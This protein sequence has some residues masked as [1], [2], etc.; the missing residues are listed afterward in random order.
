MLVRRCALFLIAAIIM[1]GVIEPGLYTALALSNSVKKFD[2]NYKL[3]PLKSEKVQKTAPL[4]EATG[5]TPEPVVVNPRGHKYEEV[6]KRTPFTSTYVNNDGTR[7]LQYSVRQQNYKD[8]DTWQKIDNTLTGTPQNIP[9]VTMPQA[10]T[11]PAQMTPAP[12]QFKG[13][14]GAIAAEMNSLSQGVTMNLAGKTITMRPIGAKDVKPVKGDDNSVTYPNAWPNVDL[15]Y[16]LRGEAVKEIIIIKDK[17]A[18]TTF[19]FAVTG[20]T[21]I[22]HP[23][24]AGELTVSGLPDEYSFSALTLDVNGRGVISEQRVTQ[25]PT[26]K[27]DGVTVAM[28]ASWMKAQPASSFPLRI[29]PSLSKDS[30]SYWMFKSDGYSCGTNCYANIGAIYDTSWKNWRT[31]VQFPYTELSGKKVV[32]ATLHG[33]F[34]YGQNGD[35]SGHYIWMG[36]APCISYGCQGGQ[37]GSTYA[38]TDFDID[39]TGALSSV[40]SAGDM[41]AVWSLWGEEG[42]YKSYKPYYDIVANITYDSPTPV[43]PTIAPVDQQVMVDTQP[44]LKVGAVTDPDGPVQYHFSVATNTDGKTGAVIQSD[45]AASPTW[46]VPEGVLQDGTTYYWRVYTRDTTSTSQSTEGPVQS[47]KV[48]LRTGKDSTQSYDTIGPV[49]VDLATGNATIAASTHTMSALGG[50]MGLNLSY[51]T[52]NTAKKGLQGE[53]WN[54]SSNYSFASGVPKDAFGNETAATMVR[55]DQNI[56]FNWGAGSPSSSIQSDWF[57]VRWTGQFVAPTTGTYTFGGNNDDNMH[58]WV[59]NVDLYNNTYT[60]GGVQYGSSIGLQAGQVVPMH[61]EYMEATSGAQAQVY[62]KGAVSEQVMPRDWL[63]TNLSNQSSSYGLT[64]RYYTD[65]SN[66]HDLDAAAADSSRL[67]LKRQDTK[68]NLNF[69]TGAATQGLQTDNFMARWTGYVTA[70]ITG[71]YTLGAYSDDGVRIKVNNGSWQT[72]LDKWQDQAG[73]F[74]GSAITLQAN[75]PTP[76]T[77]DWYE[78]TGGAAINLRIQGNGYADQEIPVTWLTPDAN[79]LPSQWKLGVDVDG[80]VGY[81]RLRVSANSVI[82]EDSTRST[83]EYTYVN[84]GYKPPVNEDGNLTKNTDNSYTFIDTDGRTY[85]FDATGKLTSLTSPADDRQPAALKYTYAG[86]PSR[87]TKIEDGVTSARYAQAYYM[88]INDNG[89]CDPSKAPN[90]PDTVFGLF[91]Q[92]DAAPTGMLCAFTTSDGNTT[93]L[94]YI[95]GNVAR[96]VQPGSQITDYAYDSLG[97]ITAMRDPLAADAVGAG[98]RANDNTVSTQ[99]SYDSLGRV[100][101]V[102]APAAKAGAAQLTHLINYAPGQT[103]MHIS[104]ASEPNGFSKRVAY[105]SLLRTTGETDLTGKTAT[106]VWDSV[107]DLQ[108]STTD[109]TGLMSTTIYDGDDR[110]TDTYG[111]APAARYGS[112][113]K[114]LASYVSQIPH[115]S[116]GYDENIS[117]P[118]VTY[119]AVPS[120][121]SSI[122]ANGESLTRGQDRRSTD[123]RF[124]FIYQTD[125]NLV[126]YG[127]NGAI[128]NSGTTSIASNGVYMQ[129]DGNLVMYNSGTPVWAS[130]TGGG[131]SAKLSIQ[132]DGN[133]VISTDSGATWATNTA[134]WTAGAGN[135]SLTG[136]PLLNTTNIGTN[137]SQV[138]NTWTS[139]PLSSGSN[140][141]GARMTGKLYLPT[142]GNWNFRIVS[143][144][145]ARLSIDDNVVINDWADG[146]SRSHPAYT[147]NNTTTNSHRLSID[148]YHLGGASA[149]FTLYMTPAG[150]SETANVSQYIKPGY[151]LTTSTTAYDSQLG[152]ITST[153]QYKDPAY[154]QVASTT[155][156]PTGINYT[157]QAT[158]EA[159]STGFL[160]QTSK[161]LPGGATTTYQHYGKDETADNPCTS[162]VEAFHQAGRPKGKVDPTGRTSTTIYNESGDVVATKYNNDPW[163]CTTY[164]SRGRVA[165]TTIPAIS[166]APSRTMTNNYAANGNPLITSTTDESGTITTENDLLGRTINYTDAKGKLTTNTYDDFGKLTQRVSPVGTETYEY[167]QFDRLVRQKLDSVLMA[168]VTYD[169]F[170]RVQRIDYPAG[171]SLSGITR[172]TLGRENSNTYTLA[173]S[174]QLADQVNRYTSGDIQNGTENGTS[175]SYTYDQAGRLTGAVIGSNT[176]SYGFGGQDASCSTPVG[177]DAGKDG[178]RTSMTADG[179]TTTYCYNSADQLISSSDPTLTN[180]QYD[181]HGNTTSLGDSSHQT[182]FTYDSSDRNTS[183]KSLGKETTFTRDAQNRIITREHKENGTTTSSVTYGFTASGD[184]PDFLTDTTGT[185]KQKYITLPGDVLVTIK[186]DSTSAGATTYSLPNIHGDIFAT[187]NADGALM[188]TFMTGPFGETLPV[189]PTLAA[190]AVAPT[191]MPLNAAPGTTYGYVGQNEK[192]TDTET[193]PILGGITQMGA[194]V[195][196]PALGRF[197]SI[198]PNEGG[199]A[200]NY[201]YVGD[202]INDFDLDGNWGINWN[203]FK[204]ITKLVT[205][206]AFFASMIPGPIGMVA[207][208][209]AVAGYLVQGDPKAAALAGVGLLGLGAAAFVGRAAIKGLQI[210]RVARVGAG[211]YSLGA[212]GRMTATFAKK[213]YLAGGGRLRAVRG[214]TI[215]QTG[216]LGGKNVMNFERYKVAPVSRNLRH[217][218]NRNNGHLVIKGWW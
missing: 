172:D 38:G 40:V 196:I 129:T 162:T 23:T 95:G 145:G 218:P 181:A 142:T 161:T 194:R 213:F 79:V 47:F 217:Y 7:S 69:G 182:Q 212:A 143:D 114:P 101:S 146:P 81:E 120:R 189:Q 8:G 56:D 163:T 63:Y 154:A 3:A 88:G 164:D 27:G 193:S 170:S 17:S 126:L 179:Q 206:V 84:G 136:A 138:S 65:N 156:D 187:V 55:R 9:T 25:S 202:P 110:A 37:V 140:Y 191:S 21:V 36:H 205:N 89:M 20:G 59:N 90:S 51:N 195:Y 66:A 46:S 28:D 155:L 91:S 86:D 102:V 2:A 128:W 44:I 112:D 117:G 64:G 105:D 68:M 35:T 49:G 80:N 151:N 184:T 157:S 34:Q 99:I 121:S 124:D 198:D 83:H 14:S 92:F 153:T 197:L 41:G 109:A 168:T 134:N 125:G 177:Y 180:A 159:P 33:Y 43:A 186:T 62:V 152:N 207:S 185:V 214:P 5:T 116:T 111:P 22:K 73:T 147:F 75:Q 131:S 39:F 130:G 6:S 50:N 71:S 166:S 135:T 107:K 4:T 52:P 45:W 167:D 53:Y 78:H 42:T 133:T 211:N 10:L 106:T 122:L 141:W 61:I 11:I 54:V 123:G 18:Q 13:K 203:T 190:E 60:A 94:Y 96:L 199:N 144:N 100:A 171:L 67:M 93:N 139:S 149:N 16:Q 160:R 29:D 192:M 158:Y 215:K 210:A 19:D 104:G 87:L 31:Y 150:G 15:E 48:D 208:G 204:S 72:V 201:V 32:S 70:P 127:P 77:L 183:V 1:F 132:N 209:V 176:Y 98:V 178:N 57:Y 74:W 108:L 188:S 30:T 82:L 137:A 97:R 115:T 200:N 76:I 85:I 173:S 12:S 216:R 165:Q 26:A 103:D 58:I 175:K 169:D 119:M 113:R 148:Y 118:A 174:T 24:R